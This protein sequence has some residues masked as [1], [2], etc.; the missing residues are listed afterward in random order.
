MDDASEPVPVNTGGAFG[1]VLDDSP[2][3]TR[4][5]PRITRIKKDPRIPGNF[6][7]LCLSECYP[8]NP[9]RLPI[10]RGRLM[11]SAYCLM[12]YFSKSLILSNS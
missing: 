8:Y 1:D 5:N 3:I 6:V 11:P 4:I 10:L 7:P 2:R 9:L 12:P